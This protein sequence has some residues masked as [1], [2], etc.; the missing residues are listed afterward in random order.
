MHRRARA[1]YAELIHASKLLPNEVQ[2]VARKEI[3]LQFRRNANV[4]PATPE[5]KRALAWGRYRLREIYTLVE[6]KKFRAMK[7]YDWENT[8]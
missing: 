3:K 1:L 4:Q 2:P 8:Q 7:A 5:F 6:I